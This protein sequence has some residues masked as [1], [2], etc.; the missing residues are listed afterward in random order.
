MSLWHDMEHA[1]M[2]LL[3]SRLVLWEFIISRSLAKKIKLHLYLLYTEHN[4]GWSVFAAEQINSSYNLP[5]LNPPAMYYSEAASL[6]IVARALLHRHWLFASTTL[7]RC[8]IRLNLSIYSASC[9]NAPLYTNRPS[10]LA[11]STNNCSIA[12]YLLRY[13]P[14][15]LSRC[16][17]DPP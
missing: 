7:N 3:A 9:S 6:V 15:A 8:N 12:T 5:W 13:P 11:A 16:L 14:A 1:L 17:W 10:K 4:M 2:D